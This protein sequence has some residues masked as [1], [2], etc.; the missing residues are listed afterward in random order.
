[1]SEV[2]N[3]RAR[4]LIGGLTLLLAV[5]SAIIILTAGNSTSQ[6]GVLT[7]IGYFFLTGWWIMS[8]V[9]AVRIIEASR[10]RNLDFVALIFW[11][12]YLLISFIPHDRG[13]FVMSELGATIYVVWF[14]GSAYIVLIDLWMAARS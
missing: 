3:A 4:R 14:F 6:P 13:V 12:T 8:S 11:V 5:L 7:S 9:V 10:D 1:M 2:L